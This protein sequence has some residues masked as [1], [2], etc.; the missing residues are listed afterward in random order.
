V[1]PQDAQV[2]YASIELAG[3]KG[4]IWRSENG[5]QS[6]NKMS[7]YTSGGTGAH[8]YQELFCDPHRFDV[9]YHANVRLG[10]TEDGGRT[11]ETVESARKHVDNHAVAFHPLDPDFL[12]VGCDG[13]LYRSY[14]RGQTYDFFS[15][16]PLTQFYKVAT[17]NERPFYNIIGGT[18]DNS[19]QYGPSRTTH[20]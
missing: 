4:G 19:T 16:L 6:F 13:G 2:V 14:D 20:S 8:Y 10:R 9:L 12:L 7:D 17:D 1:S 11:W 3:A 15:N 5:G 18:Q